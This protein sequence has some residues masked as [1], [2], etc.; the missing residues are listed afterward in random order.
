[1]IKPYKIL[2]LTQKFLVP[3]FSKS[4]EKKKREKRLPFTLEGKQKKSIFVKWIL[5]AIITDETNTPIYNPFFLGLIIGGI[6]VSAV[7]LYPFYSGIC[8]E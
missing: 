1:M 6:V 2:R 3:L 5:Y 7:A 8:K 4:G